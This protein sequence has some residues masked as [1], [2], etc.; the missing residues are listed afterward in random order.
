MFLLVIR[1][2]AF[3]IGLVAY[4]CAFFL[5]EDEQGKLVNRIDQLW[6]A[7][8]DKKKRAGGIAP[9]LLNKVAD[10]VKRTIDRIL[11][12]KLVSAQLVGVSVCYA[13]AG[14]FLSLAGMLTWMRVQLQHLEHFPTTLPPNIIQNLSLVSKAGGVIGAIILGLGVLPAIKRSVFTIFLSLI[15]LMVM[16]S[17][18]IKIALRHE[19]TAPHIALFLGLVLSFMS[20]VTL[21]AIVRMSLRRLATENRA[22][23]ILVAIAAQ[24]AAIGL[25]V[26]LPYELSGT[27]LVKYGRTG[28]LQAF[29]VLAIFNLFTGLAASLFLLTLLF[30]L[31]HRVFWPLLERIIYP[32]AARRLL[33]DAKIMAAFGTACMTAAWP[34]IRQILKGVAS[35]FGNY[36]M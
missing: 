32:V 5:H 3:V 12:R 27:L 8:D 9:A 26:L 22:S 13:L 4:Y 1:L 11:G 31:L 10:I 23:R 25:L 16:I 30:V 33:G 36:L 21:L 15:P 20:D 2:F 35:A 7:V 18:S 28:T 19:P 29:A 34:L 24:V 14:L 17:G 6:I